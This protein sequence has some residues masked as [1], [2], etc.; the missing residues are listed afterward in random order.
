MYPVTT[1]VVS[2]ICQLLRLLG[3]LA[4]GQTSWA[5]PAALPPDLLGDEDFQHVAA[6][7]YFTGSTASAKYE[8]T[9]AGYVMRYTAP[10]PSLVNQPANLPGPQL[11]IQQDFVIEAE[12]RGQGSI[13]LYWGGEVLPAG[14]AFDLFQLLLPTTGETPGFDIWR[15]R[16]GG[17]W[18]KFSG[19]ALPGSG[20]PADWHTLRVARVG[21]AVD[22]WLDGTRVWHQPWTPPAGDNLGFTVQN[23]GSEVTIRR[24]RAWHYYHINLAPGIPAGLRREQLTTPGL[25]TE[26]VET[27]PLVSADGRYLYFS[28]IMGD[29]KAIDNGVLYNTDMYVAERGTDG[30]WGNVQALG[31]PINNNVS[32]YPSYVSPDGQELLVAGLY[33]A[34]GQPNGPGDSFTHRQADGTWT[35]PQP[36]T[37]KNPQQPVFGVRNFTACLDASGTVLI[38]SAVLPT[39]LNN[40]DL[41]LRRRLA[42]GSWSASQALPAPVN[43]IGNETTPFL[44]PD[45]RTLYFSSDTHPGYGGYDVFMTRRLDESWTRWSE[46]LNLGPAVNSGQNDMYFSTTA[47]GEYAY[48][49]SSEDGKGGD[50]YRLVLPQAL[51]PTA[52]VLVRGRVLDA[53]TNLPLPAVHI[54]YEQLPDGQKAGAVTGSANGAYEIALPAGTQYGFQAEAE[55]YFAA[56]DNLDLAQTQAFGEVV[57]DL[58][59]MPVTA[60]VAALAPAAVP[61]QTEAPQTPPAMGKTLATVAIPAAVEE[62]VTLHNV[63]FVRGKPVLLAGSFPELNRLAQTLTENPGLQIRLDGHTDNT[64][65]AKDPR[66][67]QVLSE[68]RVAAVRAYLARHGVVESRLSTKGYGGSRPV[69]PND[70]EAH[71]AQN[72]R[73]EFVIVKR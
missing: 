33:T 9:P 69:A 66:P 65:D 38:H 23:A 31:Y 16:A 40:T 14:N 71:K 20:A 1:S 47:A 56:S 28:R 51:R 72:R 46:P 62:K 44:A 41:Y 37:L 59:L 63:F 39:N 17:Q 4:W 73:V 21:D 18:A 49:V 57:R 15:L 11:N 36:M 45:G 35:L 3:L 64:G 29:D 24:L 8:I 67:N 30:R 48:L 52:T 53:R 60:A 32:N 22:Y 43:T 54:R 13:G 61:L 42:D 6:G 50:I 58:Y 26:R 2:R 70:T 68:Q 34:D 12:L 19:G 10:Q 55:G 5:Q 25:N 27:S 7:H